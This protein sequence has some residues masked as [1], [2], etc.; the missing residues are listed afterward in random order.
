MNEQ[1]RPA[2][3]SLPDFGSGAVLVATIEE[4]PA[5]D[6]MKAQ[7]LGRIVVGSDGQRVQAAV[8]HTGIY[9]NRTGPW[10]QAAMPAADLSGGCYSVTRH[11]IALCMQRREQWAV[12]AS[13]RPALGMVA[14]PAGS[15]RCQRSMSAACPAKAPEG[16]RLGERVRF[17]QDCLRSIE[18]ADQYSPAEAEYHR[19][20]L[21]GALQDL[22]AHYE[23]TLRNMALFENR[24]AAEALR[25]AGVDA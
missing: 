25:E 13:M 6:A 1:N 23:A 15:S 11:A 16:A 14:R 4:W 2:G 7:R 9:V 22:T 8:C 12:P 24:G 18:N 10:R 3:S 5:G 21:V 20:Q 19:A 17:H